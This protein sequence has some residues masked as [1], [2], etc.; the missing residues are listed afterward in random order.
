MQKY[1]KMV[2]AV[3]ATVVSAIY[4]ALTGGIDATEWV[5]IAIVGVFACGIF[6]APN[7]PGA[8]YTKSVLAVLGAV[9]TVL[10]SAIVGG[11][12]QT[13][14]AQIVIAALGALGVYRLKNTDH[15]VNLSDTGTV[16]TK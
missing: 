7:V 8:R 9:L 14:L 15:G 12:D 3:V 2:A 6:T 4:P 16:G 1:L 5:N 13:E 10:A 11:I